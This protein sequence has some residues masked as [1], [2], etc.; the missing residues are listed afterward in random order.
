M[1]AFVQDLM[2]QRQLIS[3][4]LTLVSETLDYIRS[5]LSKILPEPS[6]YDSTE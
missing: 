1:Q 5:S 3:K 4:N 6:P 2:D